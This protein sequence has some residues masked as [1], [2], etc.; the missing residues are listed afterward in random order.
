[1]GGAGAAEGSRD[2]RARSVRPRGWRKIATAVWGS[3]NDPQIYGRLE[4]D[5]TPMLEAIES[6][7]RRTGAHATV[8]HLVI[9]GLALALNEVPSMNTRLAWGRFHPRSGVDVFVIVAAGGGG[10]L[11]GVKVR[12][13]DRKG[14]AEI[15][16][17]LE[18]R[19]RAAREGRGG[20]LD[21][22]KRV[23]AAMPPWMLGL[24]LRLMSFL[25]HHLNLDLKSLGMPREPFGSAMV[26]NVGVF[27]VHEGFAP[28][29]PLYK[30]P[31]IL[32]V[33]EVER[34]PWVVGDRVEVR[35]V[36]TVTATI[37][38]RWVDGHGIAALARVF[39]NY[40]ADPLAHEDAP[41]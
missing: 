40:M 15:A 20:D 7:R 3:P 26:T 33:G 37:D 5:A 23:M 11:S 17:E 18:E 25:T 12:G 22:S 13:A 2:R 16:R 35:P 30:V 32:L 29:A 31:L 27:G 36:V 4:L 14:A 19:V 38:H 34:K 28:L 21:K 9:R 6:I 39:R 24:M 1:M 10:D 8:T 41:G